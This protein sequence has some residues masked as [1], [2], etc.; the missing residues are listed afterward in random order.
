MRRA[1]IGCS[2]ALLILGLLLCW[3][4][5]KL[6]VG[7]TPTG[8]GAGFFPFW[9]SVGLMICSAVVVIKGYLDRS[10]AAKKPFVRA[11]GWA[12]VIKVAVPAF[13]MVGLTEA[14]GLYPAAG[15]YIAVYMRWIGKHG[16]ISTILVSLLLPVA[17]YFIF[18]KW[19][20][21]PMPRGRWPWIGEL[22]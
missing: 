5:L 16:W 15:I 6:E 18:D 12:P 10:P 2:L 9:L 22:Y 21:I 20:L 19:F 13:A 8:P 3:E 1:E 17:S 7:W 14:I 11:G 4:S